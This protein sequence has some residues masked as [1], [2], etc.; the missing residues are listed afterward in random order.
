MNTDF[1]KWL[2]QVNETC[3]K[4]GEAM[5]MLKNSPTDTLSMIGIEAGVT[6]ED[7]QEAVFVAGVKTRLMQYGFN[8]EDIS[9]AIEELQVKHP[10]WT[11]HEVYDG[12][13]DVLDDVLL[14]KYGGSEDGQ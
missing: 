9:T 11:M 6:L 3:V 5:D 4:L 14:K 2:K 12:L 13:D 10:D 1:D 8:I 7:I